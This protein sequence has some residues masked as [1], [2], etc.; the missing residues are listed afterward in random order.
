MSASFTGAGIWLITPPVPGRLERA[1]AVRPDVALLDL[2]DSVAE[3]GKDAARAAALAHLGTGPGLEAGVMTGLR[4]NPMDTV[5]GL[6]DVLALADSPLRDAVILLPKVESAR[7]IDIAA[8]VLDTQ[9]RRLSLWV[10][11]E[12]P[13]ALHRLQSILA[14][15]ALRG[16]VFGAGDY[17]A[18]AGCATSGTALWWARVTLAAGA[19]A[20][21]IPAIDSPYFELDN[22]VGLRAET[23][24]ARELGFAGKGAV[25][26]GQVPVIRE[27]LRPTDADV[28]AARAIVA[29]AEDA[30]DGLTR[31][32]GHM[33]GPPLV[34]AARATLARA[35]TGPVPS[36]P[37]ETTR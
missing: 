22:H 37:E 33:V 3:R 15:P 35:T 27:A 36:S 7:D 20:A 32:G 30:Q 10:L 1:L 21:G 2:E 4:I 23:A 28:A 13:R 14:A 17:A 29:A 8:Q 16:V 18:T 25:H 5:H 34:T 26:P 31:A 24:T 9:A 12:T 19:A 11:I 6:R